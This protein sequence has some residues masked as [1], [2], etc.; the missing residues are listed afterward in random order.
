MLLR[1]PGRRQCGDLAMGIG[2]LWHYTREQDREAFASQNQARAATVYRRWRALVERFDG[3]RERIRA[4]RL[5]RQ[6]RQ[7]LAR[8]PEH[9]V[10]DLGLRW[11]TREE[12]VLL[13]RDGR[14]SRREADQIAKARAARA[15][16]MPPSP[17]DPVRMG[18]TATHTPSAPSRAVQQA[19]RT[20]ALHPGSTAAH[21][22]GT[23]WAGARSNAGKVVAPSILAA[24][25][26]SSGRPATSVRASRTVKGIANAVSG[27]ITAQ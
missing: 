11:S 9:M 19:S 4:S 6:A 14:A 2:W 22:T 21:R 25:S 18:S 1:R 27:R 10:A 12:I 17:T 13:E 8:L 26:S 20:P 15:A 7:Q 24:S 23:G 16:P 3:F 5:T